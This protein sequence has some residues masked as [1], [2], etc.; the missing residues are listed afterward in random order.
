M[1]HSLNDSGDQFTA[2]LM[3]ALPYIRAFSGKTVVI[4]YG[5][6]AMKTPERKEDFVRDIVLLRYVGIR[7][8]VVHGGGPAISEMMQKLGKTPRFVG[9][10]RIT[11]E[12]T[13]K[14][15]EMVLVGDINQEIVNL[16][17]QHGG[18]AVGLSGKDGRVIEARKH[19]GGPE[20]GEKVDLGFVGDVYKIN[21]RV[22][23]ALEQS[24]F[25][26]VLAPLGVDSA[27]CTYNINADLVAGEIAAALLA[28]KLIMLSDTPGILADPKDPAT[29]LSE[30][31]VSELDRLIA[32]GV[33]SGGMIPKV[34]A[35]RRALEC[36]VSKTHIIDGRR[37]HGLL[38]EI[39]TN[40]GVGTQIVN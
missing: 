15:T 20:D 4:K 39:F 33:I 22:I 8:V 6:A 37:S 2:H 38:L 40:R 23:E 28:E 3:E 17:N 14:I 18:A 25:I 32:E 24:G 27:G 9:G 26:P 13:V 35:C 19:V 16:I 36:G 30:I 21:P 5:G 10:L 34:R 11:D 29:L 7:P 31:P 12:E 1:S